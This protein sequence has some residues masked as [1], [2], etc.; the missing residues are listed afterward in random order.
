MQQRISFTDEEL[1]RICAAAIAQARSIEQE[2]REHPMM[3][4][5]RI[6]K[7]AVELGGALLSFALRR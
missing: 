2:E 1:K 6:L 3:H 4:L 7:D 5:K